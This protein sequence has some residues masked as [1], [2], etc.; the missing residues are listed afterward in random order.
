M[1]VQGIIFQIFCQMGGIFV[2]RRPVFFARDGKVFSR[3]FDFE[4]FPGFAVSQKQRSVQSLHHA[5][6]AAVPDAS[7]LE[8]ST[9]GKEALG[10]DMS[11][12]R[13]KL[14]GHTLENVFQSA[15]VFQQAGPF[16]DLLEADPKDA[17]RDPRLKNS[18]P[19][20]A[21]RYQGQDFPLEPKT[22]FTIGFT[23]PPSKNP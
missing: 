5:V 6:L 20:T 22:V 3:M 2:A 4:W 13:L 18:G 10:V 8:V 19:L 16:G 12:F 23:A 14:C 21:F 11:A 7:P 15:K 17:K 1:Q 9:K